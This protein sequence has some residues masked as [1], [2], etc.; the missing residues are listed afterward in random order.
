VLV[1]ELM[2]GEEKLTNFSLLPVECGLLLV[3]KQYRRM[4][5]LQRKLFVKIISLSHNNVQIKTTKAFSGDSVSK[6]K[7]VHS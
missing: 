2:A 3:I 7:L 6:N 4:V 5:Y 1:V